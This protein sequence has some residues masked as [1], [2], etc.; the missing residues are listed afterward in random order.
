[1]V[2]EYRCFIDYAQNL[3][4]LHLSIRYNNFPFLSIRGAIINRKMRAPIQCKSAR[5]NPVVNTHLSINQLAVT[6]Y[7]GTGYVIYVSLHIPSL[8]YS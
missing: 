7:E 4:R 6:A 2:N 8:V 1:M 5:Q 3:Q